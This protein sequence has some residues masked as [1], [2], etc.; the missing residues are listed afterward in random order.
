MRD[1]MQ[2]KKKCIYNMHNALCYVE[3]KKREPAYKE[4][5]EA[6]RTSWN[7]VEDKLDNSAHIHKRWNML[8][9]RKLPCC[10]Q[11]S[12]TCIK[13]KILNKC[14]NLSKLK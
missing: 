3:N 14:I 6:C 7:V 1:N 4:L 10:Q 13:Y 8:E 11:L 12:T 2:H 5:M 9:G